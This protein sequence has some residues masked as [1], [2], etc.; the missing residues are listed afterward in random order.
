MHSRSPYQLKSNPSLASLVLAAALGLSLTL[1]TPAAVF[2]DGDGEP[3]T[4]EGGDVGT[5]DP[6]TSTDPANPTP[7][8]PDQ[9][10]PDQP[11]PSEP[12]PDQPSQ[13]STPGGNTSSTRPNYPSSSIGGGSNRP[14]TGNNTSASVHAPI[15]TPAQSTPSQP[16]AQSRPTQ[17]T[18]PAPEQPTQPDAPTE[19]KADTDAEIAATDPE[20]VPTAPESTASE[21]DYGSLITVLALGSSLAVVLP[22][23]IVVGHKLLTRKS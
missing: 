15:E 22:L 6:G 17:P 10:D 3:G 16:A 11:G 1:L 20:S 12:G 13:P 2:A 14:Q 19:P 8:Q 7:E 9:P 21:T 4:S 18:A 23:A 5:T